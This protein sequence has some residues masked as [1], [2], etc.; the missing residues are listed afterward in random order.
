[1]VGDIGD[2]KKG[3][4][5]YDLNS[6]DEQQYVSNYRPVRDKILCWKEIQVTATFALKRY[7]DSIYSGQL[8]PN[9]HKR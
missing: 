6:E 3:E 8:D 4:V 1:M 5:Q 9:T 2:K 7:K